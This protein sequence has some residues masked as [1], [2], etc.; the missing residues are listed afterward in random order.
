MNVHATRSLFEPNPA[1]RPLPVWAAA[2]PPLA[3]YAALFLLP[4]LPKTVARP[5]RRLATLVRF[6]LA[7]LSAYT[8]AVLPLR[9]YYP[10]SAVLT[11]Q[12]GLVG[13]YGAGRVIDV[14]FLSYPRVPSRIVISST[15]DAAG[16]KGKGTGVSHPYPAGPNET[17]KL[18]PHPR[19]LFTFER[20]WW[21]LDLLIS[22]RGV[23]WDFASADVRHDSHPWQPPSSA[24]LRRALVKL[25][26]VLLGCIFTMHTL[27]PAHTEALNP[28][29][30]D[31]STPARVAFVAATGISLY[32]LFDF[33]YTLSSAVALPV[34]ADVAVQQ[35]QRRLRKR[36]RKAGLAAKPGRRDRI[37]QVMADATP[38][39]TET[40][41]EAEGDDADDTAVGAAAGGGQHK[42]PSLLQ[43]SPQTHEQ[44]SLR[45]VD[46]FPL[47]NPAGLTQATTVRR[48]WS[49]AWHRL[50]GRFFGVYGILP[51]TYA[52]YLVEDVVQ[53]KLWDAERVRARREVWPSYH[54][55]PMRSLQRGR[56]DW[57]KV[58]GAFTASGIIHGVS[59]RAALG[60]RVAVP[61]TNVWLPKDHAR[62]M[63]HEL[64]AGMAAQSGVWGV[65]ARLS[66]MR[67]A[68]P[69]SGGGEFS[70]FVLNGVAVI[71][72]GA[73][74][75]YVTQRRKR[76]NGGE[77][78]A[79]W[80][81]R[82]V[83]IAWTLTVLLYTGQLFVEGWIRS[84]ISKELGLIVD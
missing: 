1:T 64:R 74:A 76:R 52:A 7:A 44:L 61:P 19:G 53:G 43:S 10:G 75:R 81:D 58:L 65:L 71:V 47:L 67:L 25:L 83:G 32:T 15:S 28:S 35:A 50:F 39:D 59:E 22:M 13:W 33:G 12:L 80:Y 30:T 73:V 14:F 57:A 2:V 69:V 26:P 66:P 41:T 40:E 46:F 62:G 20:A 54:A 24:Q 38:Q 55:D 77:T 31:L 78:Y 11:Y 23:G 45:N 56:A 72:E 6:G 68:P 4:P 42:P 79:M 21:A 82:P 9:Y 27:H 29:I 8:F 36:S 18:E 37:R 17:W 84:G 70:F 49:F 34:M 48:F 16:Q 5:L 3:Y 63:G 51:F 60:G